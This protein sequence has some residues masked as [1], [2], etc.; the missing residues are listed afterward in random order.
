[1]RHKPLYCTAGMVQ[2]V[3]P[4]HSEMADPSLGNVDRILLVFACALPTFDTLQVGAVRLAMSLTPSGGR[5]SAVGAL[6]VCC[7]PLTC[8]TPPACS[9]KLCVAPGEVVD[10][11]LIMLQAT[12]FLVSAEASG[13]PV[14]L[15]LN[16]ADLVSKED[17]E[18][19]MKEV[20][21]LWHAFCSPPILHV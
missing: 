13:I 19:L 1:M 10:V 7:T 9:F 17:L 14:S 11:H 2:D 3:L 4:R 5:R 12:K 15:V 8:C 20:T 21:L 6:S 18:K 16:K